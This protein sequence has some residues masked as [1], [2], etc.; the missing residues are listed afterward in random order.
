MAVKLTRTIA[1]RRVLL[2]DRLS[3]KKSELLIKIHEP[4]LVDETDPG[5]SDDEEVAICVIEFEGVDIDHIV[6][7]GVDSI[8][9]LEQAIKIDVYLKRLQK[10]YDLFF[11]SGAPYF[12]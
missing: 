4:Y 10:E 2:V 1:Q 8:H 3:H 11:M 9:A 5:Y 12:E 6:I 7:H